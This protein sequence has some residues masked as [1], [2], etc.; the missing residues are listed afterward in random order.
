MSRVEQALACFRNGFNCAQAV[1]STYGPLFGIDREMGLRL[2]QALGAGMA[3]KGQ[4]CGAVTGALLV[5]GLRHGMTRPDDKA[6]REK[7]YAL[8]REFM[9][10]FEAGNGSV[11][12][13]ELLG[14]DLGTEE[15][16]NFARA[17]NLFLTR[18]T[19]YVKSAAQIIEEIL[20]IN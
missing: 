12:C 4:T 8:A 18:C 2:G 19:Q 13:R 11:N 17:N 9:E 1:L 20:E 10:K 15:G 3:R 6:A 16:M 7:T 5:L 14:C